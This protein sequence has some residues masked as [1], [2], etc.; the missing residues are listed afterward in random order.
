MSIK[1]LFVCLGNICRS[2]LAEA[3]FKSKISQRNLDGVVAVDSAGT[4]NYHIG[5]GPDSR[6][7]ENAKLNNINIDHCAR[8]ISEE[9][10]ETFDYIIA[11]DNENY[12]NIS[13]LATLGHQKKKLFFMRGFESDGTYNPQQ[14]K[15]VPDPY[16]GGTEGFQNVFDILE[17]AC[18]NFM[19]YLSLKHPNLIK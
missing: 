11:M 1:I 14:A 2:P 12:D 6:S 4:S 17:I 13:Q 18:N 10:L 5:S 3:I 16:Y 8:Q 15:N 9:D 7:L 19:R